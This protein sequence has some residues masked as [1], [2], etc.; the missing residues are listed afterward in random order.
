V[1]NR[2][3]SISGTAAIYS[4]HP[5]QALLADAQVPQQHAFLNPTIYD[6]AGAVLMG[7]A[8]TSPAFR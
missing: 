6:S 2:I 5:L 1:V 4:D 3:V 8:P 7:M